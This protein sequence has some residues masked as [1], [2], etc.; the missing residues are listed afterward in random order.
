MDLGFLNGINISMCTLFIHAGHFKTGSSFLQS[1]FALNA[2][3]LARQGVHYPMLGDT[4]K[5]SEGGISSGNG[6]LLLDS[7]KFDR[8]KLEPGVSV[9]FSSEWLFEYLA[10]PAR[11]DKIGQII[12][13]SGFS[14]VKVLLFI[15]DPIDHLLSF[16]QQEIK[17]GGYCGSIDEY[18]G[19]FDVPERVERFLSAFERSKLNVKVDVYNYGRE[20]GD[21]VDVVGHWLGIKGETLHRPKVRFVNRSLTLGELEFQKTVNEFLGPSGDL[22]SD[23]LC[24]RLPHIESQYVWPSSDVQKGL[25]ERLT[26]AM[27]RVNKKVPTTAGYEWDY[28]EHV[29]IN[30]D[31]GGLWL[32]TSQIRIIAEGLASEISRLRDQ[33]GESEGLASEISRLRDQVGESDEKVR[34]LE[35]TAQTSSEDIRTLKKQFRAEKER[36]RR[37]KKKLSAE[38]ARMASIRASKSWRLTRP[39]RRFWR[40]LKHMRTGKRP[41]L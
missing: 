18:A 36:F 41:G 6:K 31:D 15:R 38:K 26:A 1:V 3:E 35:A 27:E 24:N 10:W 7:H 8:L 13:R 40:S 34:G 2:E 21:L 22:L 25:L 9:L 28:R 20:K 17:R 39:F 16:Y 30:S 32:S 12:E 37:T 5:A 4:A 29:D 11:L 23:L 33:V 14:R 19:T